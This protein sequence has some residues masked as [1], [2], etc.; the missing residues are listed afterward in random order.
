MCVMT[1]WLESEFT[2]NDVTVTLVNNITYHDHLYRIQK[3]LWPLM[4]AEVAK[5]HD[6]P[7]GDKNVFQLADE[8]RASSAKNTLFREIGA[9]ALDAIVKL[10]Y[11][12][13]RMS[14]TVNDWLKEC[15]VDGYKAKESPEIYGP[16]RYKQRSFF[17]TA[18]ES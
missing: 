14:H 10:G 11:D 9:A 3:A 18:L 7:T 5:T 17:K 2:F 1:E 15:I 8:F 6:E 16:L 13:N 12:R 4:C